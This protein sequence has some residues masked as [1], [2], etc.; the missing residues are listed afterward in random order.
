M[1]KFYSVQYEDEPN[2]ISLVK[3]QPFSEYVETMFWNGTL[4]KD[5]HLG[6]RGKFMLDIWLEDDGSFKIEGKFKY[7]GWLEVEV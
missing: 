7:R 3:I 2:G 4:L 1:S 6:D 5:V